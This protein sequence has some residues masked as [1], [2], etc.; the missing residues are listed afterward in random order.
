MENFALDA[1]P[2]NNLL[3][4]PGFEDGVP[5]PNIQQWDIYEAT[6]AG[7]NYAQLD[8]YGY[9]GI[10]G[11]ALASAFFAP[12]PAQIHSGD[13]A[14]RTYLDG[15][16]PFSRIHISQMVPVQSNEEY[17]ASAFVYTWGAFGQTGAYAGVMVEQYDA[18]G[19][20]IYGAEYLDAFGDPAGSYRKAATTFTTAAN[21]AF[22]KFILLAEYESAYNEGSVI[23]DDAAL[24]GPSPAPATITG[25]VT[26]AL[27]APIKGVKVTA[28]GVM[29]FTGNTGAYTLAGV[30]PSPST[31]ILV[32]K[33]GFG[34]QSTEVLLVPGSTAIQNFV[35]DPVNLLSDPGF[36]SPVPYVELA[37]T[38][39]TTH[40]AWNFKQLERSGYTAFW[41]EAEAAVYFVPQP[42]QINSGANALRTWLGYNGPFSRMHV[43]QM[44]PVVPGATYTA[45][46][47]VYAWGTF[48]QAGDFAGVTVEQ[49][50][51][52]GNLI[53]A[54]TYSDGFTTASDAYRQ[55]LVTFT[56]ASNAASVRYVLRAEYA[57]I[58]T[59]GSVIFDTAGLYGPAPG[60]SMQTVADAKASA[61]G[62]AVQMTGK[63]VTCAFGGFFYI[64]EADRSSGIKVLD[65]F[66][67]VPG[68]TITIVGT[69]LTQDGERV[70]E[71]AFVQKTG[72]IDALLPLGMS[73]R[74]AWTDL[75]IGLYAVVYGRVDAVGGNPFTITDGSGNSIRVYGPSGYS[76]APN[77]FVS[78][79]GALGSGT[80]GTGRACH[81]VSVV[82]QE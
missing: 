7:W 17:T 58:Y 51:A 14:L 1:V 65:S 62:T 54:G 75:A 64:E 41:G 42:A 37:G 35:L 59:E 76:A 61:D 15:I 79:E 40:G 13:E 29:A 4:N 27:G 46:G 2:T 74:D 20:L 55:A 26:S 78:A 80:G 11:E 57:S 24:D 18:L 47:Y 66:G 70:I 10:S 16:A 5:V 33:L 50:D 34:S 39:D 48:G 32:T 31:T 23:F 72:A 28:G 81:A 38:Y 19:E 43:S 44:V 52:A 67:L 30:V 6:V 3:L 71:P 53:A 36:E 63:V 82:S 49:Y 77:G 69:M 68:D 73:N 25:T 8:Y 60:A 9:M 56:T 21:T 12:Q 45:S 22:L